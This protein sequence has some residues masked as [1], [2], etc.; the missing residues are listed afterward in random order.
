MYADVAVCLPF[1]RTFLYEI[2]TEPRLP[3]RVRVPF[4]KR[5]IQGFVVGLRPD[6]PP[7]LAAVRPVTEVMDAEP[8]VRPDIFRVVPVDCRLLHGAAR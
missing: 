3:A 8:L 4:G 2:S 6:R 1:S 5:E 7:E